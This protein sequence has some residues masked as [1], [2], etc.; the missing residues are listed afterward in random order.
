MPF[1]VL[2]DVE[3]IFLVVVRKVLVTGM[4]CDVVLVGEE[5]P[6]APKLQ[7]T[8]AAVHDGDL[9]LRHQLLA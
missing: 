9:I 4:L 5:R 6:H 2:F 8:L 3:G 7:D 1:H